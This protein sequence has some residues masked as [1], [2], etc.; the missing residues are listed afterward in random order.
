MCVAAKQTNGRNERYERDKDET[1]NFQ[2]V[3]AKINFMEKNGMEQF[4]KL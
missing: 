1:S 4:I 3:E 2:G